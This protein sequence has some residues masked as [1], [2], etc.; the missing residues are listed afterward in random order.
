MLTLP[1]GLT[2]EEEALQKRFAKLRKKVS[3]WTHA[4]PQRPLIASPFPPHPLNAV[5]PQKKALLALKKQQSNTGPSSQGGIKRCESGWGGALRE[6]GRL[7]APQG[8]RDA[9]GSRW[10][11]AWLMWGWDLGKGVGGAGFVLTLGGVRL[12]PPTA[13]MSDQPPVDTATATEQAKLLVKSGAISAIKAETKNSGF[14]RSRTLEGKLKVRSV[15]M[16]PSK[17]KSQGR[18]APRAPHR[19]TELPSNPM[20][21]ALKHQSSTKTSPKH[22]KFHKKNPDLATNS[23]KTAPRTPQILQKGPKMPQNTQKRS[24]S[25]KTHQTTS[26]FLHF[27]S[28]HPTK[29]FPFWPKSHPEMLSL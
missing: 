9:G 14:K 19:T 11:E 18:S 27:A 13:A 5:S 6:G 24:R 15:K 12:S 2:E 28:N 26:Y 21:T 29:S 7:G 22:H 16:N 20:E 17:K 10:G 4:D 25:P 3:A 8:L 23:T 1:P